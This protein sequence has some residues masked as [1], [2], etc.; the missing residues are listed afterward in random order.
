MPKDLMQ[1]AKAGN[2][3]PQDVALDNMLTPKEGRTFI[4]AII[5]Q[6]SI[7]KDVTVDI[8]GKLTKKRTGFDIGTGVLNRHTSGVAVPSANMKKIESLGCNLN[9]TNGVS[10]NARILNETLL[11]N[12]DNKNFE[13][14]TFEGF[15]TTFM[16]DLAFLGFAGTADNVAA[17]APFAE[18]S[19]GWLKV[20]QE[21]TVPHKKTFKLTSHKTVIERLQEVVK[22]LDNAI[23]GGKATIFMSAIDYDQYQL[24]ASAAYP[25]S[26][27]LIHGGINKYAGYKLYPQYNIPQHTFLATLPK[28]MVFGISTQIQRIRWYDNETSSLR[29]KFVCHPDYEFDIHK[30]I[31]LITKA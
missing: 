31:T 6:D 2:I 13:K 7:L 26:G 25:G 5:K 10:L 12:K 11:D 30:Y 1:I 29:Y 19:K 24:E 20:A 22:N 23:K 4:A 16:N 21:S 9:M 17:T 28:N 3:S 27:A 18:L 8:A 15:S 14:D